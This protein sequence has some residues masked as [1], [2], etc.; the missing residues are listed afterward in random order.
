MLF[1][2]FSSL[3]LASVYKIYIRSYRNAVSPLLSVTL[4]Q[5][6][7]DLRG[8][9]S[10]CIVLRFESTQNLWTESFQTCFVRD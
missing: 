8:N 9:F 4:R 6:R 2:Q 7:S 10:M 5:T 1:H 3:I